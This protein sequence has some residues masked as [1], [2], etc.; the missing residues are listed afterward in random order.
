MHRIMKA[1][2]E[3]FQ[4]LLESETDPTKRAMELRL[5]AEEEAN[6]EELLKSGKNT[7]AY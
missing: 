5:L 7:K 4:K 6:L 1:N 3:R 2:I